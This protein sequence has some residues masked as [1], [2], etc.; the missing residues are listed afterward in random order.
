MNNLQYHGLPMCDQLMCL[1]QEHSGFPQAFIRLLKAAVLALLPL[2]VFHKQTLRS[3]NWWKP[4]PEIF[5]PLVLG[6][7]DRGRESR[8]SGITAGCWPCC[9]FLRLGKLRTPTLLLVSLREGKLSFPHWSGF[10]WQVHRF[11]SISNLTPRRNPVII[12]SALFGKVNTTTPSKGGSYV[13]HDPIPQASPS[14]LDFYCIFGT[15][16]K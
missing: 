11:T 3:G 15:Y 12:F 14:F 1:N 4:E 10:P 9:L 16:L 7:R 6:W 8:R 5:T 2:N 13:H